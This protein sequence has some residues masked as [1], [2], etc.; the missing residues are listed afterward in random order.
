MK[1]KIF[2]SIIADVEDGDVLN[3][4]AKNNPGVEFKPEPEL[5]QEINPDLL[6]IEE[7]TTLDRIF[8]GIGDVFKDAEKFKTK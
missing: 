8:K 2:Y 1:V 6:E 3:A 5:T 4:F 7:P